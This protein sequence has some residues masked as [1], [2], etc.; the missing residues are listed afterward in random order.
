MEGQGH[1]GEARA[2]GHGACGLALEVLADPAADW[3]VNRL[4]LATTVP[5]RSVGLIR[6][7]GGVT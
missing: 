6:V 2:G 3:G 1:G 4:S 7:G 5:L